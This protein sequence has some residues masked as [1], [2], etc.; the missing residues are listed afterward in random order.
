MIKT[1]IHMYY[2]NGDFLEED[3]YVDTTFAVRPVVGD[4]LHLTDK[5]TL[6]FQEKLENSGLLNL[7]HI[8]NPEDRIEV[9]SVFLP[10]NKDCIQIEI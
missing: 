2:K 5:Q 7:P 8:I 3:V 6:Y 10:Q 4:I 9:K 1:R